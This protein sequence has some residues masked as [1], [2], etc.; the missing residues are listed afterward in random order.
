MFQELKFQLSTAILT[1][2]TL[3][4]GVAAFVNLEAQYRIRLPDDGVTWGDRNGA[5]VA[6]AVPPRSPGANAGIHDG[7]RLKSIQGIPV[8]QA[9]DVARNLFGIRSWHYGDYWLSR[10]GIEFPARVLVGELPPPDRVLLY[11][12]AVGCA[13]L[14]IGLFVYFR[15]GSAH[16]AQHFYIFCLSSFIFLCAHYTGKLNAFD[17][18]IYYANVAAGL[19]AAALFLHFA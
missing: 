12:Y 6:L 19:L 16:K 17:K 4:A 9:T 1:V 8:A 7:D 15:R 5:V 13:Y 14:L 10:G 2:I 18:T 3:A 11:E